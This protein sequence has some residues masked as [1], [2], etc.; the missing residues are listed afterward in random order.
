MEITERGQVTI[1]IKL[2]EPREVIHLNFSLD[3]RSRKCYR[4]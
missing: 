3:Q 4:N 2:R 1:P